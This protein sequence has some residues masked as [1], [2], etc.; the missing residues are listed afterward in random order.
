ME[1]RYVKRKLEEGEEGD[2]SMVNKNKRLKN[3]ESERQQYHDT[4][5]LYIGCRLRS[6]T[7]Q[8]HYILLHRLVEEYN[9]DENAAKTKLEQLMKMTPIALLQDPTYP[10][11][12]SEWTDNYLPDFKMF[13]SFKLRSMTEKQLTEFTSNLTIDNPDYKELFGVRDQNE[14]QS[15]LTVFS[16]EYKYEYNKINGYDNIYLLCQSIFEDDFCAFLM[17]QCC[18][19][20][21]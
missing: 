21:A 14:L 8:Q 4:I 13:I 5:N 15:L 19:T 2:H 20:T 10:L 11:L 18:A 17:S 7:V 3:S 12:E 9:S 6:S 16:H 1:S